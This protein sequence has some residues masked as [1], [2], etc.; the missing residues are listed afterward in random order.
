MYGMIII[1]V[2]IFIIIF[3]KYRQDINKDKDQTYFLSQLIP[4]LE[5]NDT[6]T[7]ERLIKEME[8][9]A[10]PYGTD[11]S[12]GDMI[13]GE[14]APPLEDLLRS[15]ILTNTEKLEC[16]RQITAQRL[17]FIGLPPFLKFRWNWSE[18]EEIYHRI[19]YP[20]LHEEQEHFLSQLILALKKNDTAAIKKLIEEM[21]ARAISYAESKKRG[22]FQY[23]RK[24]NTS[25]SDLEYLLLAENLTNTVKI[26]CLRQIGTQKI[27]FLNYYYRDNLG[28][29]RHKKRG[30]IY[31]ILKTKSIKDKKHCTT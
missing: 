30:K 25:L 14:L 23:H 20:K 28:L 24:Q 16:L 4:A 13:D 22:L 11:D 6:A 12:Q 31:K 3:I 29:L 19:L 27:D 17:N 10:K 15:E 26:E 21:E 1:L 9:R 5:E 7:I 2:A 18:I 8:E